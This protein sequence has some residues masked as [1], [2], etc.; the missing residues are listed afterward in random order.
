[1]KVLVEAMCLAWIEVDTDTGDV[2]RV[3]V[4]GLP[5]NV[6]VL[7]DPDVVAADPDDG[8]VDDDLRQI[9]VE[10]AQTKP[11]PPPTLRR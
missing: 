4:H 8:V 3:W 6:L 7:P 2:V 1:M 10:V 5:D 11:L 9:A